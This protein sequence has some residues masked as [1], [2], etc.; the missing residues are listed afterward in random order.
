MGSS[1]NVVVRGEL[2]VDRLLD[3]IVEKR[4]YIKMSQ[5]NWGNRKIFFLRVGHHWTRRNERTRD[6]KQKIGKKGVFRGRT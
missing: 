6:D 3:W 4:K 5:P 2:D 1:I